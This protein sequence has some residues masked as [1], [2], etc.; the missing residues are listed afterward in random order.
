MRY[1]IRAHK[2]LYVET[3]LWEDQGG[4]IPDVCVDGKKEVDTGLVTALGHVIYRL[5]DPIGFGRDHER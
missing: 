1:V 4:M 5:P 3:P 2:P